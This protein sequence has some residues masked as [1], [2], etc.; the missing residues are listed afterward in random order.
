MSYA[1]TV[2]VRLKV[3]DVAA[4]SALH[5]IQRR[6]GH[7]DVERLERADV[8]QVHVE[9][10]D[11]HAALALVE[12]MTEQTALFMNPN[13]HTVSYRLGEVASEAEGGH[14]YTRQ[15]EDAKADLMLDA[16]RADKRFGQAVVSV[17]RGTLWT[18]HA[19]A[20]GKS[21]ANE[22]ACTKSRAEGLF[23]NPHSQ[24]ANVL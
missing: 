18:I 13:K 19:G 17:Q 23:A 15:R 6:L 2:L 22:L 16:L 5:T 4:A 12:T 14:V 9:A 21:I 20:H 24:D 7:A 10:N 11:E 1:V 3:P 8:F